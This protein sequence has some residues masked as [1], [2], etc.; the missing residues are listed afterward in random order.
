[1]LTG[2]DDLTDEPNEEVVIDIYSVMNGIEGYPSYLTLAVND[3][4]LAKIRGQKYLDQNADGLHHTNEPGVNGFTIIL[5]NNATG[6]VTRH[7]L[8]MTSIS[9]KILR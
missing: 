7:K 4:D 2:L 8:H 1:M 5:V 9:M 3:D 6:A